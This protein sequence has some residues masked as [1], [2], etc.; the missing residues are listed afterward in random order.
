MN[1]RTHKISNPRAFTLIE[2]LVVISIIGVLIAL[3]LPAVQSAREAGRRASCINNLK[4][5]GLAIAQYETQGRILPLGG[6]LQ[7]PTDAGSG[8]TTG[9][10]HGPRGFG[11]FA[12]ILPYLEQRNV[13]NSINFLLATSGTFGPVDAGL[14][15]YTAL[16]P[17]LAAYIC[18]SDDPLAAQ[19]R[20]ASRLRRRRTSLPAGPGTRSFI[21]PVP[22]AGSR[23]RAMARS[24]RSP[25]TGSPKS[26]T[27]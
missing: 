5:L 8:C 2:L 14:S 1:L 12:F 6:N 9:S 19:A 16:A 20:R 25:R 26:P 24:T 11:M 18:P 4:Q 13:Y 10:V 15:N 7:G 21:S 27:G 23:N 3:L 22:I 17:V